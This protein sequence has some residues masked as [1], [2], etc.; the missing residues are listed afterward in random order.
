M[1]EQKARK[2]LEAYRETDEDTGESFGY[3]VQNYSGE[4]NGTFFFECKVDGVEYHD[5]D[6]FPVIAVFQNGTILVL[7]S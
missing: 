1:T 3:S 2:I 6:S 4:D 7:P 5:G